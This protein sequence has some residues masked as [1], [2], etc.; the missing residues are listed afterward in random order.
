[1]TRE[2]FLDFIDD[3]C[4]ARI[5]HYEAVKSGDIS[6]I[7]SAYHNYEDMIENFWSALNE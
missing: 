3:I 2:E 4:Y 7:I 6:S 5:D 1:M